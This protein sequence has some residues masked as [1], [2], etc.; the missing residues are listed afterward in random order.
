MNK[1]EFLSASLPY[2]LKC[3]YEGG[4]D[5]YPYHFEFG[6]EQYKYN[7]YE[8]ALEEGLIECLNFIK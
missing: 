6:D 2:E 8:S 4:I 5:E 7:D 3:Q 1:Q